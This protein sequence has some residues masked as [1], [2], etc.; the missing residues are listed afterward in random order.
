MGLILFP[1]CTFPQEG[2]YQ[3]ALALVNSTVDVC[4]SLVR[5]QV[6]DLFS[7]QIRLAICFF[8]VCSPRL[9]IYLSTYLP[10]VVCNISVLALP[11]FV[12]Q[13]VCISL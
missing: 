8:A 13:C 5:E 3:A 10:V 4:M 6:D 11:E 1:F 2:R 7:R 12:Y 9:C